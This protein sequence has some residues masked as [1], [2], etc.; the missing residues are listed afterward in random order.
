MRYAWEER[1]EILNFYTGIVVILF[2]R[3]FR[4]MIKSERII[5]TRVYRLL[6]M[7]MI[8]PAIPLVIPGSP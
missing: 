3:I 6:I 4:I 1:V 8:S 2:F 5:C 7:H